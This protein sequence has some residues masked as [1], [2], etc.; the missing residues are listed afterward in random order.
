MARVPFMLF[1]SGTSKGP[2]FLRSD[3]E[4]VPASFNALVRTQ[5]E[6]AADG[7]LDHRS[8]LIAA[9]LVGSGHVYGVDGIGGGRSSTNK[10]VIVES[11]NE[12]AEE[13][14]LIKFVQSEIE[15]FGVDTTHGDCGNMLPSVG[16]FAIEKGLVRKGLTCP[17][18][19]VKLRSLNTGTRYEIEVQ[20]ENEAGGIRVRYSGNQAI[21][22]VPGSCAP[23]SVRARGMAGTLGRGILPTGNAVDEVGGIEVSCIDFSRPMVLCKAS[24]V[25]MTGEETKEECDADVELNERM[26]NLRRGAA[27]LMGMG[28]V[29]AETSPKIAVLS[30][31]RGDDDISVRYFTDPRHRD[32]HYSLAMTAA[33]C[34]AAACLTEGSLAQSLVSRPLGEP[35]ST[36][37][38]SIRHPSGTAEISI[39]LDADFNAI[40][41]GYV[42]TVRPIAQ[43]VAFYPLQ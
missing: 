18:T 5:V 9:R 41:A 8:E 42:R 11:A 39:G 6:D 7:G 25:G 26:E 28:D 15:S 17:S 33:Q 16:A 31:A 12:D 38:V 13:D 23:V 2:L 4:R 43:G 29:S 37:D 35:E 22:G 1:R 20:T 10:S 34:I 32:L 36:T 30:S 24:D 21:S 3:L 14:V 19:T 27:R 40:S